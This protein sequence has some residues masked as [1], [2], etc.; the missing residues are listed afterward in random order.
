MKIKEYISTDLDIPEDLIN[1]ALENAHLLIKHIKIKKKD[2]KFRTVL[3]PSRKLKTVQYWLIFNVFQD[4]SV[5][6]S[7]MA[8]RKGISVKANAERHKNNHY[9]LKIDLENYFPSISSQDLLPLVKSWYERESKEWEYD[10][11]FEGLLKRA[12]F[13]KNG[14]LPIGFPSSPI[15]SNIVMYSFDSKISSIFENNEDIYG[16]VVYTRYADDMVFSTNKIGACNEILKLM[17]KVI[18]ETESPNIRINRKKTFFGSSKGGSAFITGLRVCHDGHLTIHRKY[19]D[20]IRLLLSLFKKD[21]LK[22]DDYSSLKG[23]LAFIKNADPAFYTKLQKKY[24]E[25]ISQL[26]KS[27]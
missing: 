3:Q 19:K 22:E 20:R 2:G 6:D 26:L 21:E 18:D 13:D 25:T 4:L 1:E 15:I 11:I 9:F 12:C 14:R 16:N 8:Y 5:H 23:H 24:F 27:N 10:L 7:A 17:E